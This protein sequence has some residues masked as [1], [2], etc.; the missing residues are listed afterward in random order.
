MGDKN[1]WPWLHQVQ[2]L[3]YWSNRAMESANHFPELLETCGM[4]YQSGTSSTATCASNTPTSI[5]AYR[6]SPQHSDFEKVTNPDSLPTKHEKNLETIWN[7]KNSHK[8]SE[9][10]RT[11]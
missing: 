9:A 3:L 2:P 6:S 11:T 1:Q 4:I 5:T 7:E 10:S 8:T